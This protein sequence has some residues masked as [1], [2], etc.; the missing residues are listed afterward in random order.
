MLIMIIVM[1]IIIIIVIIFNMIILGREAKQGSKLIVNGCHVFSNK[2]RVFVFPLKI[3][4][5]RTTNSPIYY[6]FSSKRAKL[7]EYFTIIFPKSIFMF[8]FIKS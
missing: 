7:N 3:P 8:Y 6:K 2:Q 4:N 1:I 5:A